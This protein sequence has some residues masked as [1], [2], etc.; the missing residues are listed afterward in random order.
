MLFIFAIV[1]CEVVLLSFKALV[2]SGQSEWY[3]LRQNRVSCLNTE[4]VKRANLIWLY[5]LIWTQ[6]ALFQECNHIHPCS[7]LKAK[8]SELLLSLLKRINTH[9][10]S[11]LSFFKYLNIWI[12]FL[13]NL[14]F[15]KICLNE[16][17]L[18]YQ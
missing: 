15:L 3:V 2:H 8:H 7:F 1:L 6:H 5:N 11:L 4:A 10:F 9:S 14:I 17:L 18:S 13:I 12:L 16:I